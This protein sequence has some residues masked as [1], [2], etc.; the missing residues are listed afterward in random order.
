MVFRL[1]VVPAQSMVRLLEI[2]ALMLSLL[3]PQEISVFASAW[4]IAVGNAHGADCEH[5][6]PDPKS[7][8]NKVAAVT[9]GECKKT[10]ANATRGAAML[11]SLMAKLRTVV[12]FAH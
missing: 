12:G 7:E 2:V 9:G 11:G 5:E 8:K 4:L 6:V 10:I 1:A 3:S